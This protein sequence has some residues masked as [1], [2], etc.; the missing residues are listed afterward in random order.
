M[1]P[2]GEVEHIHRHNKRNLGVNFL[3]GWIEELIS[4]CKMQT[5]I[6]LKS[7]TNLRDTRAEIFPSFFPPKEIAITL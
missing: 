1:K 3:D 7:K 4:T 2:G 6:F 5:G